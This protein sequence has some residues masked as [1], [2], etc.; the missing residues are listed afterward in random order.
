MIGVGASPYDF[1]KDMRV[2]VAGVNV[3]EAATRT[4]KSGRLSFRNLRSQLWWAL[5]EALD[6][7]NNTGI[8]LPPDARLKADLC[9]PKWQVEGATVSVESREALVKRL[10]RSPDYGSAYALALLEGGRRAPPGQQGAHA[11]SRRSYDPLDHIN[12]P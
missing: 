5:R 2:N 1:L 8:A 4:D 12:R 6:P 7:V 3:A 9:A 10:G 11:A